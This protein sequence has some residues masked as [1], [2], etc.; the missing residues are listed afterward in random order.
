MNSPILSYAGRLDKEVTG[1][2]IL[3]QN[4]ALVNRYLQA[5]R[6]TFCS[7]ISPRKVVPKVYHLTA[8]L[9]FSGNEPGIL[10]KGIQLGNSKRGNTESV[11]P[12]DFE[13][14]DLHKNMAK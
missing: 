2:V 3:S 13:L 10:S 12:V 4:G 5:Q 1:L 6:L 7:I 9:K 14:L 11:N 8:K